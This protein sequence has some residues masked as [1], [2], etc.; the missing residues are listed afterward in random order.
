VLG[1]VIECLRD[2]SV[3]E[4]RLSVDGGRPVVGGSI[5]S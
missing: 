5:N 2:D 4:C 3:R 1:G